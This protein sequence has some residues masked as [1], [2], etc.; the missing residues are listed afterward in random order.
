MVLK[1]KQKALIIDDE[2]SIRRLLRTALDAEEIEVFEATNGKEGLSAAIANRPDF[3]LLDLGLPDEDGAKTL[4]SLRQW[5]RHP[6]LILSVR[7]QEE[8]IV[9]ALDAGADDYLT[10]PFNLKELMARIRVAERHYTGEEQPTVTLGN[11]E[12]DLTKRLVFRQGKE[13][14]LTATEYDV[15]RVMIRHR[16]KVLTHRQLLNEI[17]GPHASEHVQYL[18]VYIGHLRQKLEADPNNPQLIL[19]E[20]GVGY[21]LAD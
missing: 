6:I 17:W 18:R 12:V 2:A 8:T 1:K 7:N 5:Y 13:V 3:I 14:H 19:T 9:A 4:T 21:R 11:S 16:G 15:L 10:K 20:P